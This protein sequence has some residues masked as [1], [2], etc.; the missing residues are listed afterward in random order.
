MDRLCGYFGRLLRVSLDKHVVQV[1]KIDPS[2]LRRYL[3]GTGYGA[4]V[5]YD[6]IPKGVDALSE[7][8]KLMF[9]TSPLTAKR[10]P[11]G[12]SVMLCFKSP[13]TNAWGESR[14]GGDFGPDL[15]SAGYDAVVIEGRSSSPVYLSIDDDEVT[16][17]SAAHLRGKL[18]SEKV[19]IIRGELNDPRVSV[20]CI[21][22]GGENLSRIAS[23]MCEHRAAGR[24]GAGAVMGRRFPT[25]A[26]VGDP[27]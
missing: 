17:K 27:P 6:E 25:A 4:R 18:V 10:I 24:G 16:L 12:G 23:V 7:A 8:N 21:G 13:A 2:A 11:G 14:C 26:G 15:K 22:P 20:M 9:I 3:G 5:L 1:E 19:R